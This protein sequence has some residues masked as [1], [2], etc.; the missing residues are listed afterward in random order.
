MPRSINNSKVT[1]PDLQSGP[2]M[3]AALL[4]FW[5]VFGATI[6][7]QLMSPCPKVFQYE[8]RPEEPDR[9]YGTAVVTGTQDLTGVWFRV[10]LDGPSIQLGVSTQQ[11]FYE[12]LFHIYLINIY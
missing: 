5:G 6:S 3:L 2:S 12:R 8:Q 7:Q 1:Y 4:V 9:W 10:V 11:V